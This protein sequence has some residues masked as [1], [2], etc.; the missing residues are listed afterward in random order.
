LEMR[1]FQISNKIQELQKEQVEGG[2]QGRDT[3][4]VPLLGRKTQ[5][6]SRSRTNTVEWRVE[7][8][9]KNYTGVRNESRVGLTTRNHIMRE[10]QE[11]EPSPTRSSGIEMESNQ[12]L[13]QGNERKK[14]RK[15][16]KKKKMD[17]PSSS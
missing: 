10:G 1:K 8:S 7:D 4:E 13:S 11:K 17:R 14:G 9:D 5:R 3:G 2:E 16:Q 12:G 15:L 6:L